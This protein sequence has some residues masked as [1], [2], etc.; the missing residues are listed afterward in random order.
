LTA[1]AALRKIGPLESA[2]RVLLIGCGG[3]GMMGIQFA[4]AVL[5]QAPLVADVDRARLE[6]ALACGAAL[7]YD[8]GDAGTPERIRADSGG[9]PAPAG[10]FVG[11]GRRLAP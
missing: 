11:S 2:E 3:V 8:A 9:G 10:G 5:G 7:A 1:F 6:A 4:K